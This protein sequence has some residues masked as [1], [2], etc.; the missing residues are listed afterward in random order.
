MGLFS[1]QVLKVWVCRPSKA[2]TDATLEN[3]D[4]APECGA[5]SIFKFPTSTPA[6]V[7]STPAS[8]SPP[9]GFVFDP[10]VKSTIGHLI[11][12]G[13]DTNCGIE[14]MDYVPDFVGKS[15]FKLPTESSK[16]PSSV[17]PKSSAP[18]GFVFNPSAKSTV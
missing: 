17:A 3:Q 4:Y 7:S 12:T 11:H 14:N 1:T 10:T 8:V 16:T 6:T 18:V 9:V 15:S 13:S 5:P 2:I